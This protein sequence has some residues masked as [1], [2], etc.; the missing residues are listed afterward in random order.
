MKNYTKELLRVLKELRTR[1]FPL[2]S[3]CAKDQVCL[4]C[5]GNKLCEVMVNELVEKVEAE[6]INA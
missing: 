2:E 1:S 4:V 3:P 5:K 6:Q